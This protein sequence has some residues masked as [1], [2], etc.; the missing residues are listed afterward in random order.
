MACG[1]GPLS[2]VNTMPVTAPDDT[3]LV[4]F[5]DANSV[6]LPLMVAFGAPPVQFSAISPERSASPSARTKGDWPA[7]LQVK[8]WP[9]RLTANT[10]T[11]RKS[12][13][14]EYCRWDI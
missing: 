14:S 2:A 7:A 10:P 6:R 11:A 12:E 9:G 5:T 4:M 1:P 3:R 8:F 13:E